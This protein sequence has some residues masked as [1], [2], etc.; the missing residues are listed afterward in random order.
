MALWASSWAGRRHGCCPAGE[1]QRAGAAAQQTTRSRSARGMAPSR[2]EAPSAP[3]LAAGVAAAPCP[4]AYHGRGCPREGFA[5]EPPGEAWPP[6]WG[7]AHLLSH[8]GPGGAGDA[9][10]RTTPGP[11]PGPQ[12]LG[13][14][15]TATPSPAEPSPTPAAVA[16]LRPGA[17]RAGRGPRGDKPSAQW[18]FRGLEGSLA[19]FVQ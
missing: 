3:P 12:L 16:T 17:L 1:I 2:G 8:P 13:G 14:Q 9:G 6:S 7:S 4:P 10:P 5:W 15:A 18:N 11:C 19:S